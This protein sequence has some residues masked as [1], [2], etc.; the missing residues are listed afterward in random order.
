VTSF[1]PIVDIMFR[2][3]DRSRYIRSKFKVG[4]KKRFFATD[5]GNKGPGEF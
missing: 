4:H 5:R 3:R 1:F 2:Y